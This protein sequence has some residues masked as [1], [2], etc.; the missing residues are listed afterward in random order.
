[1]SPPPTAAL[2]PAA[3]AGAASVPGP[4]PVDL[5]VPPP[6]LPGEGVWVPGARVPGGAAADYT[7]F[8][9]PDPAHGSVVAAVAWLNQRLVRT[10]VI[11]GTK[12]PRGAAGPE[13]GAVPAAWRS[14]LLATFNSGFKMKDCTCGSFLDGVQHPALRDGAAST[15]GISS[16]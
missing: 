4:R 5:P 11:A 10:T 1:V 3:S 2:P 7:T 15:N 12:E 14:A 8:L 13:G 16:P 6:S 9:R